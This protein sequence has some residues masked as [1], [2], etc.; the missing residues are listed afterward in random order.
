MSR[1]FVHVDS[2][3]ISASIFVVFLLFKGHY[4]SK[5]IQRLS[6]VKLVRQSM[7]RRTEKSYPLISL[8]YHSYLASLAI[9]ALN[10]L[11]KLKIHHRPVKVTQ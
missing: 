7:V 8:T 3:E 9:L 1:I 2:I 6:T 11:Q 4:T 5:K 10:W